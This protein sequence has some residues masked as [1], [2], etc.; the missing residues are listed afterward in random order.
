M[1]RAYIVGARETFKYLEPITVCWTDLLMLVHYS[2]IS[3]AKA[4]EGGEWES[5]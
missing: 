4:I 1:R 3:R 5:D 2:Y